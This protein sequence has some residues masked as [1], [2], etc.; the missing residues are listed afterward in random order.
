MVAVHKT[1]IA[2]EVSAVFL[3]TF[4]K[5]LLD[6][7]NYR[8]IVMNLLPHLPESFQHFLRRL[9]P[10]LLK[11]KGRRRLIDFHGL[12]IS[13]QSHQTVYLHQIIFL[14]KVNSAGL[15]AKFQKFFVLL[16]FPQQSG[17]LIDAVH[18]QLLVLAAFDGNPLL[19]GQLRKEFPPVHSAGFL[20][21]LRFLVRIRLLKRFFSCKAE[22]VR[23]PF[24]RNRAVIPA[25]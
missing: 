24:Q 4:L 1:R 11:V 12:L 6:I 25:V 21:Q 10:Q 9:Q 5:S 16:S 13:S 23:I 2:A 18:V 3:F 20:K 7:G 15:S 8:S 17:S 22:P 19:A 14:E